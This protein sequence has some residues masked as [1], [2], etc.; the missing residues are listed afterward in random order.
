VARRPRAYRW[1]RGLCTSF[2]FLLVA[3]R[4][5]AAPGEALE[6]YTMGPGAELFERFG[7]AALCVVQVVPDADSG[8]TRTGRCYNYG[9]TDFASPPQ[10]IGWAFVRGTARFWVSVGSLQSM[11]RVYRAHDRSVYRQRLLL[12]PEATRAGI[13][14]LEHDALPENRYYLYHHFDDNCS[15][16]VR[17]LIDRSSGGRLAAQA[18]GVSSRSYRELAAQALSG[19]TTL[20]M[21]GDLAVGRRAD[22][23]PSPYAAMFLPDILRQE[24]ELGL[25]AGPEVVFLRRGPLLAQ[26]APVVWP[27]FVLIAVAFAG[28]VA[29]VSSLRIEPRYARSMAGVVLGGLGLLLITLGAL[30]QVAE[31]RSNEMFLVF[32]PTDLL[33]IGLSGRNARRYARWR[34]AELGFVSLLQAAGVLVQPLYAPLLVPLLALLWLSRPAAPDL[35]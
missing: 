29:A 33:L 11:L 5:G 25:G 20:V 22:Q 18:R 23:V 1:L 19:E 17:D 24:V 13:A 28:L 30:T 34:V 26:A 12:D 6:L 32:V 35:E 3:S 16:R 7:H 8:E 10:E 27:W 31:L 2:L 14:A 4:A 21:L 15:T 9:T